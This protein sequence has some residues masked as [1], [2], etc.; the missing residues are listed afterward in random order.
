MGAM[1]WT[2]GIIFSIRR[3]YGNDERG[4]DGDAGADDR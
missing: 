1:G 3:R 4:G 2:D